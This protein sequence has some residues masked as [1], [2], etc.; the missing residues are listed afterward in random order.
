MVFEN[1]SA[2]RLPCNY[3]TLVFVN[4]NAFRINMTIVAVFNIFASLPTIV[5]N[6]LILMAMYKKSSL[7]KCSNKILSSLALSD[8]LSGLFVQ[9]TIA[10]ILLI[11]NVK[12][13]LDVPC[14]LLVF[15]SCVGYTLACVSLLTVSLVSWERYTAVF[16]PYLYNRHVSS[17]FLFVMC[18]FVWVVSCTLIF[19]LYFLGKHEVFFWINAV[20][21][22]FSYLWN[23]YVYIQ[24]MLQV[25][26]IQHEAKKLRERLG[27]GKNTSVN[28]SKGMRL[29]AM[30][31]LILLTCYF[32]QIVLSIWRM[33]PDYPL[34]VDGYLEY[35]SM[36]IGPFASSLN[37]WVYCYYNSEIRKEVF[38][39]IFTCLPTKEK[40]AIYDKN[41]NKKYAIQS[42]KTTTNFHDEQRGTPSNDSTHKRLNNNTNV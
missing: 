16:H 17:R 33:I 42:F 37:P 18:T 7:C 9:T 20:V 29:A 34:F 12:T 1:Y 26:K 14:A 36:T 15:T 3:A 35:W 6:I 22:T 23:I 38:N 25:N 5:L 4:E 24:I 39:I 13:P 2:I 10:T 19:L 41:K 31:I 27:A 40:N 32:P 30:V 8:L 28:H 21:I 11:S